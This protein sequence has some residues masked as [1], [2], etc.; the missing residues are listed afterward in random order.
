VIHEITGPD[1]VV[2]YFYF[3]FRNKRQR[4]DIMLRS[5]IWQLSGQTP[6]RHSFLEKLYKAL[7]DGA[8]Y[9]QPVELQRVLEDLLSELDQTYIVIDGLD[10]C[11]KTDWKPLIQFIC[12]LGHPGK[13]AVHLLFTSQPLEEFKTAFK[14]VTFIEL[15][16]AV[17]TR[18]I[19]AFVGSEIPTLGNWAS[20]DNYAKNVTEQIVRKSNGMLV[21]S[22]RC[23]LS[24]S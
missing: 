24:S 7:G 4:M 20:H 9:P 8:R 2:A 22:S 3:D 12:S 17:S 16:S 18:D 23:N 21:L 13:N 15:G 10:E 6:S 14:D 1:C 5:I 19:R 11:N